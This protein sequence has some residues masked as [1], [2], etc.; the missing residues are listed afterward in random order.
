MLKGKYDSNNNFWLKVSSNLRQKE[1]ES[2]SLFYICK[3]VPKAG[4]RWSGKEAVLLGRLAFPDVCKNT[5]PYSI[6]QPTACSS[7]Q[8]CTYV[9]TATSISTSWRYVLGAGDSW[10]EASWLLR[11]LHRKPAGVWKKKKGKETWMGVDRLSPAG[12]PTPPPTYPEATTWL[13]WYLP[14]TAGESPRLFCGS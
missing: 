4:T 13:S 11:A 8:A 12:L 7:I 5:W 9:S 2:F 3:H 6:S 10:K 14:G 1:R